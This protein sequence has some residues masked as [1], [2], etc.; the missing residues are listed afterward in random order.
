MI[1]LNVD[2]LDF[3]A[4]D[5]LGS[6]V[7]GLMLILGT[8]VPPPPHQIHVLLELQNMTLLEN[9]GFSLV[10]LV[11]KSSSYVEPISSVESRTW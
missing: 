2:L 7:G 6:G 11:R 1:C 10:S 5:S 9:R 4:G 3:P 8:I